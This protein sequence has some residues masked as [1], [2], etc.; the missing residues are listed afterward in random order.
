MNKCFLGIGISFILLTSCDNQHA[1]TNKTLADKKVEKTQQSS[2]QDLQKYPVH[3]F[4]DATTFARFCY[5]QIY[6]QNFKSIENHYVSAF[7]CSPQIFIDTTTVQHLG[8]IL[9][10]KLD[11]VCIWG[12]NAASGLSIQLTVKNFIIN[13]VTPFSLT[14]KNL[15]IKTYLDTLP[16]RGTSIQNITHLFPN[17]EYVVF[18]VPPTTKEGFDWKSVVYVVEK[19]GEKYRLKATAYNH[20]MP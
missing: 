17:C 16:I 20:W 11:S 5:Q 2:L 14:D 8:K 7:T 4:K 3:R 9:F 13:Y 18:K 10:N 12:S 6:M 19:L 15:R 1:S